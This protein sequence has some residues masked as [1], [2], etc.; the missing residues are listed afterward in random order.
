MLIA[1]MNSS[2]EQIVGQVDVEWKFA[3]SKLWI[4]F[5]GEGCTV[6]VPFNI[7]PTPKAFMY[8][9]NSFRKLFVNCYKEKLHRNNWET[10]RQRVKQVKEREARYQVVMRELTKRYIMQKLRSSENDTV[11]PYDL[12]EIKG[13]ISAFRHELLDIL[14]SNGMKIP[15]R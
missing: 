8:M 12:S 15:D 3:R 7:I 6:P 11:S 9:L 13:D 10:I 14:K 1:M 4:S 2:Y 5:F